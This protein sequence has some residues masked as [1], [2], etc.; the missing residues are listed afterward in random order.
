MWKLTLGY[1]ITKESGENL[2]IINKTKHMTTNEQKKYKM[3]SRKSW[4]TKKP[5][6]RANCKGM[7]TNQVLKPLHPPLL[8]KSQEAYSKNFSQNFR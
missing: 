3:E 5:P 7:G 1:D 6:K 8:L 4:Q 2:P